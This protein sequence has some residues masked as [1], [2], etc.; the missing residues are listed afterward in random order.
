[1]ETFL[2]FFHTDIANHGLPRNVLLIPDSM[3]KCKS[4]HVMQC[5]LSK[6]LKFHEIREKILIHKNNFTVVLVYQ[7]YKNN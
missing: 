6:S 2:H 5:D 3:E 7:D 4:N 1:M